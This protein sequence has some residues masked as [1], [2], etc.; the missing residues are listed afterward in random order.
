MGFGSLI[1][2]QTFGSATSDS[3]IPD[4]GVVGLSSQISQFPNT[5][6]FFQTLCNQQ[7]VSQCRFGLALTSNGS[8]TQVLGDL[9]PS[10][11]S[12]NLTVAP[13]I[14]QWFLTG[15]LAINGKIIAQDLLIE[16]DSGTATIIG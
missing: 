14:Y 6:S 5:T 11:Y 10:L 7:I 1:T 8:G 15:D 9:D 3:P 4:D 12:G 2:N 13:I 16:M